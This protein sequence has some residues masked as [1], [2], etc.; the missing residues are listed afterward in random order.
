[1]ARKRNRRSPGEGSVFLRPD[2]GKY[3]A[4]QAVGVTPRG[5]IR[6]ISKSF[7]TRSEAVAW[8][9]EQ[10]A[11]IGRGASI[12]NNATLQD[13]YDRWLDAGEKLKGWE[14][15]TVDSYRRVLTTYVLAHLG[16]ARVRDITSGDVED[17]LTRLATEGASAS[18]LKRVRS[19]L[20]TVMRYARRR[21]IIQFNPVEDTDPPAAP[22]PRKER[23][24]ETEVARVVRTCLERNDQTARYVLVAL[25]TGLR[26]EEMLG[27]TWAGVNLEEREVSVLQVAPAG[28]KKTLRTGGKTNAANRTLPVDSFTASVLAAQREHIEEQKLVREALNAKRARLGKEPL[29]WHDFDLVFCTRVG[30]VLGRDTLRRAFNDLQ[31]AADVTQI[32]LYATRST[33]GSL[34][35]DKGVNLHALAER[36]GHTDPRFT[37]RVYLKGSSSAHRAVADQVGDLLEAARCSSVAEGVSIP[38]RG[39]PTAGVKGGADTRKV[40]LQRQLKPG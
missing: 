4:S 33:H 28:P 1:M 36:L 17:L 21:K 29:P 14:A 38:L 10:Q 7:D 16:T 3:Q 35:A 18:M 22:E 32:R 27:L 34:L 39:T 19:Y 8:L 9:A 31:E 40:S 2:T 6:R 5:N 26:T 11:A 25:G 24:S 37:A 13:V 30:T 12:G 20:N 23:W 15:A